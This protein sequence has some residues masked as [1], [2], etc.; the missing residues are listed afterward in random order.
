M[1]GIKIRTI[2]EVSLNSR[3]GLNSQYRYDVPI[4]ELGFPY[5]PIRQILA[6]LGLPTMDIRLG[7]AHPRGYLGMIREANKI[8]SQFP[9]DKEFVRELFINERFYVEDNCYVRSLK[10]NQVFYAPLYGRQEEIDAFRSFLSGINSIGIHYKDITGV[11]QLSISQL[12]NE[13]ANAYQIN[14]KRE[15][16]A[17]KYTIHLLTPTSI[18]AP[19]N[20]G[21]KT[22]LHIPGGEIR[23]AIL[24]YCEQTELH[25]VLK[26]MTFSNAYISDGDKRFVP[27]PLSMSVVK[28]DKEELRC[29]LSSGKDPRQVEQDITL[30]NAFADEFECHSMRYTKPETERIV[31]YTGELLDALRPGQTLCGLVYGSD[32][33]LRSLAEHIQSNPRISIGALA[34]EGFGEALLDI[35][36]MLEDD[37][38]TETLARQFDIVCLSH[39][40]ILDDDG[41]PSCNPHSLLAEVERIL[42]IKGQFRF[43]AAY[44]DYY[45]DYDYRFDWH[46]YGSVVRCIRAGSILRVSTTDDTPVNIAPLRHSFIGENQSCGYGEIMLLPALNLY[47]R[48]AEKISLAKYCMDL[49]ISYPNLSKG[50]SFINSMLTLKLRKYVKALAALDCVEYDNNIPTDIPV[51]TEILYEMKNNYNP[52]TDIRLVEKWYME[53]VKENV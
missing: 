37:P 53:G 16:K 1:L 12:E 19:Y 43:T 52:D 28:L 51:P 10:A 18:H 42:G 13:H 25:N 31:S 50:A 11:V 46:Q 45:N 32:P 47:Y 7:F 20:D 38:G 4:D 34:E 2:G 40:V 9:N 41:N 26:Q 35:S 27:V 6:E 15:Y 14:S 49:P 29:R 21:T 33:S 8:E 30:Y 5:L 24:K 3:V 44:T 22:H 23:G 17:L 48:H 39:T 36:D